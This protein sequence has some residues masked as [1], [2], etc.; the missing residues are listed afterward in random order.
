[1]TNKPLD[2][3]LQVFCRYHL[4]K[5]CFAPF[6]GQDFPAWQAFVYLLRCYAH[7]GNES[8]IAAMRATLDCVQHT[9]AVLSVFVQSIPGVLDW[10]DVGRIWPKLCDRI[11]IR[12]AREPI[13]VRAFVAIEK[14]EAY[15]KGSDQVEVI[16]K[17]HGWQP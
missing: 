6:T 13:D 4:G 5:G 3:E 10:G 17:R 11:F 1:M 9:E 14:T 7:G 12:G 8:A 15:R 16:I 2:K